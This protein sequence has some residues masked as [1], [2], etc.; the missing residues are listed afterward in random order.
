MKRSLKTYSCTYCRHAGPMFRLP[1]RQ[2]HCHCE[3]PDTNVHVWGEPVS[4]NPSAWATLRS[5]FDTC[6]EFQPKGG[7][8]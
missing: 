8:K 4:D 7:A 2:A 6:K 5:L 3:H 1:G